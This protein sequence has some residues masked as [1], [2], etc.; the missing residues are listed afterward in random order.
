MSDPS[1]A[2]ERSDSAD[3]SA[4]GDPPAIGEPSAA[5][6]PAVTSA[7]RPVAFAA[8][9]IGRQP[10]GS[11]RATWLAAVLIALSALAVYSNSFQGDFVFDD[12][13]WIVINP[14]IHQLWPLGEVLFPANKD[15][16]SGRPVL[17]LTLAIDYAISGT[18]VLGY[19]VVNLAIH[20][21]AG[22]L[23]FGIVR[24][25]LVMPVLGGRFAA[26]ATP[27]AAAVALV[28]IVHPLQTAAVTYVIQ[29]TE[30]LV[31]LFYL[32]TLYC[33]IRGATSTRSRWW[34]LAAVAACVLGMGTKEVMATAPIVIWLYDRT[35]LSGSFRGACKARGILYLAM[36][37]TWGVVAWCLIS[38][39]FHS[40]S[41]GFGTAEF[42]AESYAL[43][44][45]GVIV[46]YLQLVFWPVGMCLD[47]GWPA[48]TT[49]GAILPPALLLIGLA[50]LTVWALFKHPPL[51]FLGAWFFLI[52]G[53]TSSFVPIRDAAFDHR[54][55]LPLAAVVALVVICGFAV[56]DRFAERERAGRSI[57]SVRR[58]AVP[59][60]F[61]MAAVVGL[62]WA[63]MRRNDLFAS[64]E[65]IWKDVLARNPTSARAHNNLAAKLLDDGK[66]DEALVQCRR[67]LALRSR[68]ADAESNLGLAL[69]R[70]GKTDESLVDYRRALEFDPQQR[71]ALSLLAHALEKRGQTEEAAGLYRRFLEIAPEN[72]EAHFEL[73]NCLR[74]N[75]KLGDAIR[76]YKSAI[77]LAPD[78]PAALDHLAAAYAAAG[79]FPLAVATAK[80]APGAGRGR[81]KRGLGRA[82][83]RPTQ[84]LRNGPTRS[85]TSTS[86]ELAL[87][88]RGRQRREH[89][90]QKF[91]RQTD[92]IRRTAVDDMDPAEPVLVS[93]ASGLAFPQPALHIFG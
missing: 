67:A 14:T 53:P 34:Y 19:H 83:S 44:E 92:D 25:T 82:A 59:I 68:Y 38:T 72:A 91:Q 35:F 17:N 66:V 69:E 79:Q 51:G 55:Y 61:V 6:A 73:A 18:N 93:K 57:S 85:G 2:P 74:K 76:A 13:S 52:L 21:L 5:A 31:G 28:W 88:V 30:S 42:T 37:A 12:I 58:W 80:Q 16:A 27:L 50:G 62:G 8:P 33:V 86:G 36:V 87:R 49:A 77:E 60:G 71:S 46:H 56:W 47:Y 40:G 90:G 11:R 78:Y 7:A 81:P 45:P 65:E 10:L 43:T 64:G 9:S 63:T 70:L 41:T 1:A 75:G 15:F 20:I 32:L 89:F 22:L 23:L 48:A 3:P 24:R 84:A 39:G 4:I 54:M 29:R 26:A